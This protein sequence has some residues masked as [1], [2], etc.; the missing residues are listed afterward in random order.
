MTLKKSTAKAFIFQ[1]SVWQHIVALGY[2][3]LLNTNR[4]SYVGKSIC[5]C[6]RRMTLKYHYKFKVIHI[7]GHS[8]FKHFYLIRGIITNPTIQS[9]LTAGIATAHEEDH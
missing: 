5:T 1:A 6:K 3:L 2:I 8:Y 4:K 7:Q 9:R